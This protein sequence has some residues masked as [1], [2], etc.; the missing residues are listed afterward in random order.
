MKRL[1]LVLGLLAGPVAAGPAEDE[2]LRLLQG[3]WKVVSAELGGDL[4]PGNDLADLRLTIRDRTWT[5]ELH[6]SRDRGTLTV[7]VSQRPRAMNLVG[8][9]GPTRGKTLLAVYDLSGDM[10]RVCYALD[11]K[12]RPAGFESK[13]GTQLIVVTYQRVPR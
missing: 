8:T 4:C 13:R 3:N 7:D 1:A 11:G 12:E 5:V 2:D 6:G 9:E 10:L